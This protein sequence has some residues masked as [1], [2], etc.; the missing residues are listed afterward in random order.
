MVI[1]AI[2]LLSSCGAGTGLCFKTNSKVNLCSSSS[3]G[4]GGGTATSSGGNFTISGNGA[5]TTF[6]GSN[7]G[8]RTTSQGMGATA[9]SAVKQ[10]DGKIIAVGYHDA[11]GHNN[12]MLVR[13]YADGTI[14]TTY[15]TAGLVSTDFLGGGHDYAYGSVIQSNDFVVTIGENDMSSTNTACFISRYNTAGVVDTTFGPGGYHAS[16]YGAT[17]SY[18]YAGAIQTDGKIVAVGYANFG[19]SHR[20]LIT[21]L[22]TT[23][24]LDASATINLGA[25]SPNTFRSVVVLPD[26][27]I[28]AAGYVHTGA[29]DD[30]FIA[31]FNSSLALD[32]NFGGGGTGYRTFDAGGGVT[33]RAN[34]LVYDSSGNLYV[35]GYTSSGADQFMVVKF[36]SAGIVDTTFGTAGVATY[37]VTA[38]SDQGNAIGLQ[39]DGKIVVGG[40][41]GAAPAAHNFTLVR[42]LSTGVLDTP[43]GTAGAYQIDTTGVANQDILYGLLVYDSSSIIGVGTAKTGANYDFSIAKFK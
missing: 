40:M 30:T 43:F 37:N 38:G 39:S 1:P 35:G 12:Q 42:F 36:T 21:R 19:A 11:G 5:D 29:T 20:P 27:S 18:C 23:G 41:A 14:D 32:T 22:T 2:I 7:N 34:G 6:G 15:G 10:S 24:T 8:Y 25:T 3:G 9:Y 33:D 16:Y 31:K 4:G 26:G 17:F 13:Y 28:V